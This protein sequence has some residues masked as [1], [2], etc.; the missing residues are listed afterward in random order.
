MGRKRESVLHGGV[1]SVEFAGEIGVGDH[2]IVR[3]EMVALVT[4]RA[5]PDLGGEVD[6]SVR[7]EN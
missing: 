7:V 2:G 6:A 4:E 3:R 1:L 5:D